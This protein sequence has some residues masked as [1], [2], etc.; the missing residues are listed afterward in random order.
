MEIY[1]HSRQDGAL[2]LVEAEPTWT[3][4][5]FLA[6]SGAP[7]GADAWLEDGDASLERTSTLADVGVRE[8]AHLHLSTC[9]KVAVSVRYGGDTK[10]REFPPGATIASV[11]A[12]ATGPKGFDLTPTE[13][14]KHT[15]ALCDGNTELDR[16]AH[17]GSF[18]DDDC[19]ACLDLA[20]KER[21]EG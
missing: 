2:K 11:F 18:A 6:R 14:A 10:S 7:E 21:F 13:R 3:V 8:R 5:E 9:R 17:I 4:E 12:W 1:L 20:P 16:S 19:S 15:L